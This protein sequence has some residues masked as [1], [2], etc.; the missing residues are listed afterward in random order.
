MSSVSN[1][2]PAVTGSLILD[3]YVEVAF[4]RVYLS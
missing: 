4:F 1:Q 3:D 2:E